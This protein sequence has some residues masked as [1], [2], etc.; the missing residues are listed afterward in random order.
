MKQIIEQISLDSLCFKFAN[1]GSYYFIE[2]LFVNTFPSI[3]N[4]IP[5][6]TKLC[7]L[8]LCIAINLS[9]DTDARHRQIK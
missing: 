5:N 6:I 9:G 2:I 8:Y 7:K 1:I 3:K 4:Y